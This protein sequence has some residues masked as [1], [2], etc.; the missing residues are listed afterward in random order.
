MSRVAIKKKIKE[1]STSA[2][3]SHLMDLKLD[4]VTC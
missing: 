3:L 4:K 2:K 1:I